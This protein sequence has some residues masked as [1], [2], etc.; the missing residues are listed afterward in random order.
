MSSG[1][2][3]FALLA[4]NAP[5]FRLRAKL[6]PAESVAKALVA[7][8]AEYVNH[9]SDPGGQK[10]MN[11]DQAPGKIICEK[12][13]PGAAGTDKPQTITLK[14]DD[15]LGERRNGIVLLEVE[16]PAPSAG[17]TKRA[18]AQALVQV[19]DLGAIWKTSRGGEMLAYA[20]SLT[21]T[22]PAASARVQLLDAKGS[23]LGEAT[24]DAEGLARLPGKLLDKAAW[25]SVSTGE[26]CHVISFERG[27]RTTIGTYGFHLPPTAYPSD[28]EEGLDGADAGK[29]VAKARRT[30][31]FFSDRGVYKPGETAQLKA[32][33]R[34]WHDGGLVAPAPKTAATLRAYDARGRKF[35]EKEAA[36]G[37]TGSPRGIHP[38]PQRPR[39][40]ATAWSPASTP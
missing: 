14:W 12:V 30:V 19:T 22:H 25:L 26:D 28:D 1:R 34:E 36:V 40:A 8:E 18:G 16:Q 13:L 6:I 21:D 5:E 9:E 27:E 4:R 24:A 15:I 32:T 23:P 10:R 17:Q 2:R 3:E 37:V 31:L 20:F 38:P 7:Y 35:W 39:W 33:V 29:Y 11:F